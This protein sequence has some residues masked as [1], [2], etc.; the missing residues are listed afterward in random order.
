MHDSIII[1]NP[2]VI[3]TCPYEQVLTSDFKTAEG[4][5]L[6]STDKK[7]LLQILRKVGDCDI[8]MYVTYEGFFVTLQNNAK[9]LPIS[10]DSSTIVTDMIL[11]ESDFKNYELRKALEVIDKRMCDIMLGLIK[12]SSH[13]SRDFVV[14]KNYNNNDLILYNEFGTLLIP[15]CVQV[16]EIE[17]HNTS[18]CYSGIPA[19]FV[20]NKERINGFLTSD[21]ILTRTSD[22]INCDDTRDRSYFLKNSQILIR[23]IGSKIL[24]ENK[25]NVIK[26]TINF[27]SV[28]MTGMNLPTP[29]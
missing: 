14:V 24:V 20:V 19:S 17:V 26:K 25:K 4:N 12:A 22:L 15:Q 11:S 8:T 29:N 21:N 5:I 23:Q 7:L 16:K 28:N 2:N 10:L 9:G 1:W 6:I 27:N 18:N 13:G 3:H